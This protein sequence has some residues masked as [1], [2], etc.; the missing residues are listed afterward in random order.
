ML[1]IDF[2]QQWFGLSDLAMGEALFETPLYRDFADLSGIVVRIPDRVSILRFGKT[3]SP[4]HLFEEHQLSIQILATVNSTPSAEGL[5]PKNG[6]AIGATLIAAATRSTK[7]SSGERDPQMHQTKKGNQWHFGMQAHIGVDAVSGLVHSVVG[8]AANVNDV[9]Q[10]S[11][12]VHGEEVDVFSD[13]G[14]QGVAK[15]KETQDTDVNWH[16]AMRPGMRRTRD[17]ATPKGGIMDKLEQ[18]KASI[19][20]KVEHPLRLIK[21]QFG[22]VK[23]RYRGRMK[24]TVQLHTLFVL[25]NLWMAQHRLLQ[26]AEVR[27]L[28]LSE[29]RRG[30][31]K[32]SLAGLTLEREL[33]SVAAAAGQLTT[34][35]RPTVVDN[36]FPPSGCLFDRSVLISCTTS[37]N[38]C[39]RGATKGLDDAEGRNRLL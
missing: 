39:A 20:A 33:S 17:K 2:L 31:D 27:W 29:H 8:T 35:A 3:P 5:L 38:E 21:R 32:W 22:Y 16:V 25:S 36:S 14:Y 28:R 9:T 6:A 34:N 24:N 18:E 13:G 23:V 11:S 4:R 7:N 30:F 15:R 37:R 19:C 1:R 12:L 10:A 26:R